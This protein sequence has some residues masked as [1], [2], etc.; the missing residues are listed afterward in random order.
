MQRRRFLKGTAAGIGAAAAASSFPTPSVSQGRVQWKMVLTWPKNFPALGTGSQRLVESVSAMSEGRFE[1]KIFGA[2]ELVPAF[3]AFDAVRGGIAECSHD[4][5]YYWV[6]KHPAMPF[7]CSVPGGLTAIEHLNWVYFGGGQV[8]WDELYDGFGLRAFL[9]GSGG[10]NV[11]GWFN[12]EIQS[13]DD[14]KGLRMRIPGHGGELINRMGGVAVNLPG[15][16]ILTAMQSGTID[17]ADWVAPY[18]DLAFGLHKAAEYYY[19]PGVHEPGPAAAITVNNEAYDALPTAFQEMLKRAAGD[20]AVRMLAEMSY[21]NAKALTVLV[22]KHGVKLRKFPAIVLSEMLRHGAEIAAE[23]SETDGLS[24][25]IYESWS[26][27]RREAVALAPLTELGFMRHRH[28][29]G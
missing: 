4:V 8:L 11:G 15:G 5:P 13:L 23:V 21:G 22:E 24:K 9:A 28:E 6:S 16:E 20:E 14:F 26:S 25:R 12:K 19:A 29:S 2:G 3:E 10:P 18:N 27:Y 7:F 1:I 17:A